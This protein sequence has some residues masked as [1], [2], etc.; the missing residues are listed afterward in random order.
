MAQTPAAKAAINKAKGANTPDWV[1]KRSKIDPNA[2][3][4][5]ANDRQR[6]EFLKKLGYDI[7]VDGVAGPQTM[8]AWR[9]YRSAVQHGLNTKNAAAYWSNHSVRALSRKSSG[10]KGKDAGSTDRSA[11][12]D[13]TGSTGTTTDTSG[14]GG[15]ATLIKSIFAPVNPKA[16]QREANMAA[17]AKWGGVIGEAKRTFDQMLANDKAAQGETQGWLKSMIYQFGQGSQ[18][19]QDLIAS[20]QGQGNPV[21]DQITDPAAREQVAKVAGISNDA[22]NAAATSAQSFG[23]AMKAALGAYSADILNRLGRSQHNNQ[24]EARAQYLDK[25]AQRNNDRASLFQDAVDRT[26]ARRSEQIKQFS[27]LTLLDPQMQGAELDNLLKKMNIDLIGAKTVATLRGDQPKP[28]KPPSSSSIRMASTNALASVVGE[29]GTIRPEL[30]GHIPQIV[31]L[32]NSGFV[33]AGLH[34]TDKGVQAARDS[35][36]KRFGIQPDPRWKF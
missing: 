30:K 29:D 4:S 19:T 22:T 9:N 3:I 18:A 7:A 2:P 24:V 21:L 36:L 25:L 27:T 17:N 33:G 13:T 26:M 6:Q 35:L 23:E 31:R 20:Q 34:S 15:S 14:L 1:K 12:V 5:F 16:A 8:A 10:S 32:I 28:P 11:A